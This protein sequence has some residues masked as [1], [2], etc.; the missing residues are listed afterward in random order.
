M[1]DARKAL[2]DLREY[3]EQKRNL[4]IRLKAATDAKATESEAFLIS[5]LLEREAAC[6]DHAM[7]MVATVI[8]EQNL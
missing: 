1:A 2:H 6:Y 8:R 3:F 7:D 5:D 4:A